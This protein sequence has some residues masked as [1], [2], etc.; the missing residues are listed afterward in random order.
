MTS[1]FNFGAHPGRVDGAAPTTEA[2]TRASKATPNLI[3][4]G[5]RIFRGFERPQGRLE[6]HMLG[7]LY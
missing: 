2:H 6:P 3:V 4:S 7:N 1:S 5:M